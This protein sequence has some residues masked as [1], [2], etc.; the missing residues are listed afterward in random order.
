MGFSLPPQWKRPMAVMEPRYTV[1]TRRT[2]KSRVLDKME[3]QI[4]REMKE[5][6]KQVEFCSITQDGWTSMANQ[7]YETATVHYVT[8]D[9]KSKV[10]TT[11]KVEES[12]TSEAIRGAMQ[13]V[14]ANWKLPNP[15]AVTANEVILLLRHCCNGCRCL[16]S[17]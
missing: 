8:E 12:H 4:T 7:S 14:K 10:L 15:T 9:M 11:E 1:P 13:V 6:L 2:L 5:D 17:T 16:S 3:A